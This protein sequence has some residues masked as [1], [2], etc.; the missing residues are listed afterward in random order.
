MFPVAFT[1]DEVAEQLRVGRTTVYRLLKSGELPSF[2]IG[3]SRRIS[4]DSLQAYVEGL[5]S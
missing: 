4:L 2:R 1:I 3:R 5:A